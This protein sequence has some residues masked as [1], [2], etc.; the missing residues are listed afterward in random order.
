MGPFRR[1]A[2]LMVAKQTLASE[3]V[4]LTKERDE[5]LRAVAFLTRENQRLRSDNADLAL[6]GAG[7]Y[8]RA[9]AEH[10]DEPSNLTDERHHRYGQ[11][12]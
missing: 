8:S 2:A 1:F 10:E 5:A 6:T 12:R 7:A 4:G 9:L 11:A 3:L